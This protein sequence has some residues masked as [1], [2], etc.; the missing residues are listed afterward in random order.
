MNRMG[1]ALLLIT[2][3]LA[4]A[5]FAQTYKIDWYS[6][7]SGGGKVSGGGFVLNGTVGQAAAGETSGTSLLHWIGFW[8]PE[9][10]FPDPVVVVSAAEAK[11][12]PDGTLI[13]ISGKI[14]SSAA[15][16]F[17]DFFYMQESDRSSGIRVSA[18]LGAIP[19]LV[20]GSV[21]NVI[22]T[23]GTTGSGERHIT[24]P[25]VVIETSTNPPD[26]LGMY[27]RA[28]AGGNATDQHGVSDGFGLSNIGLLVRTW[29][30]VTYVDPALEF[31]YID[32]GSGI[33]D[34]SGHAGVRIRIQELA[35]TPAADQYLT[36][37]GIS[38]LYKPGSDRLRLVMPRSVDDIERKQ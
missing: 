10:E 18:P 5:A 22:G 7:N 33:G 16:E 6:I 36:V 32:D 25:M 8:V 19:G 12:E 30:R 9:Q 17:A 34:G 38:G 21:V 28:I 14:A 37:T 1:I 27:N 29:G 35:I 2:L 4:S 24:G 23:M 11:L 26:P 3:M 20:R 15:G 13:S 31:F